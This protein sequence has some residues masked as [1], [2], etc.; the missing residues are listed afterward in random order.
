[1]RRGR[2]RSEGING[3]EDFECNHEG[4]LIGA[5]GGIAGAVEDLELAIAYARK[6]PGIRSGP[7][8]LAGQSRGGFLAMHYVGLK[9]SEVM[10]AW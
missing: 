7:L 10:G 9:P 3:E 1:M 5:S 8:L 2:G 6:L 4:N